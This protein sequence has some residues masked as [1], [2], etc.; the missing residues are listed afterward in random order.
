MSIEFNCFEKI[1]IL[2]PTGANFSGVYSSFDYINL[3]AYGGEE[4]VTANTDEEV[5]AAFL[6][7]GIAVKFDG[8][9]IIILNTSI[10]STNITSSANPEVKFTNS[11][12]TEVCYTDENR[13]NLSAYGGET[14]EFI[15]SL[16]DLKTRLEALLEVEVTVTSCNIIFDKYTGPAT[17]IIIGSDPQ[18]V[19]TYNLSQINFDATVYNAIDL[20]PYGGTTVKVT[21]LSEIEAAFNSLGINVTATNNEITLNEYL[22]TPNNVELCLIDTFNVNELVFD[23]VLF[24]TIYGGTLVMNTPEQ[25]VAQFALYNIETSFTLDVD[26]YVFTVITPVCTN[27][28]DLNTELF[29]VINAEDDI[30]ENCI[31]YNTTYSYNILAN[32]SNIDGEEVTHINGEQ[33]ING[34]IVNINAGLDIKYISNG[35]I[36]I[37]SDNDYVS[38]LTDQVSYSIING[39]GQTASAVIQ[40][41]I[42]DDPVANPD[43]ITIACNSS[44]GIIPVLDND[45]TA[46]NDLTIT[47]INNTA[48]TT[49]VD[50]NLFQGFDIININTEVGFEIVTSDNYQGI[51]AISYTVTNSAFTDVGNID[52][53]VEVCDPCLTDSIG[54]VTSSGCGSLCWET[55]TSLGSPVTNYILQFLDSNGSPVVNAVGDIIKVANG[56]FYDASTTLPANTCIPFRSGEYTIEILDSDLGQ[57]LICE[58]LGFTMFPVACGLGPCNFGYSGPGGVASSLQFDIEVGEGSTINI[59]SFNPYTIPDGI[60]IEYN[61][62]VIYHTGYSAA[63]PYLSSTQT[64]FNCNNISY[65][66]TPV[67]LPFSDTI[68]VP[69]VAGVNT[70]LVSVFGNPCQGTKWDLDISAEGCFAPSEMTTSFLSDGGS[71]TTGTVREGIFTIENIGNTDI[72]SAKLMIE[73]P[74]SNL[75]FAEYLND[76]DGPLT[77]FATL[78][79][80]NN[81]DWDVYANPNNTLDLRLKEGKVIP[82]GESSILGFRFTGIRGIGNP[83][84][85]A[86]IVTSSGGDVNPAN[87]QSQFTFNMAQPN[88]ELIPQYQ[89]SSNTYSEGDS[90]D[91]IVRVRNTGTAPTQGNIQFIVYDLN[92]YNLNFNPAQIS[93]LDIFAST[94]V[95]NNP[96]WTKT[97]EPGKTVY[98][99]TTPIPGGGESKIVFNVSSTL[100]NN[101]ENLTISILEGA[102]L[103]LDGTNNTV[104]KT[105]STS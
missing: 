60:V 45:Y 2:T 20:A 5:I 68:N 65:V 15:Y 81:S 43:L 46:Y 24:P 84:I 99:S 103:D 50:L 105:L 7:I 90:I 18:I 92:G 30:L 101:V 47:H 88:V 6:D 53:T 1:T 69:Y 85:Q 11:I 71:F 58:S 37:I 89:L 86:T 13:F 100:A 73:L 61:G 22:G 36:E 94:I 4:F 97:I 95:T 77:F 62:N 66:S 93:A 56:S 41:C 55:L 64:S 102:G 63:M 82:I 21:S 76:E 57:N 51:G 35:N 28:V 49:G 91:H 10:S 34:S 67:P 29:N 31:L 32:D 40:F 27:L 39:D 87:N 9:N 59:I 42:A 12:G 70:A 38:D 16:E 54:F 96:D 79:D 17:N 33:V 52:Y 83:Q 78:F 25:I 98:T 19:Y 80:L 26:K 44:T 8:F 72:I 3:S 23:K 75:I 14:I 74:D 48:V 104:T